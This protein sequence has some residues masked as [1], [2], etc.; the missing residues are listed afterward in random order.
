MAFNPEMEYVAL[1]CAG[2]TYILAEALLASVVAACDL[3]SAIAPGEPT[4]QADVLVRFAGSRLEGATFQHPFLDRSILGVT[5]P[6]VT[7]EQG[8]GGGPH[9]AGSRCR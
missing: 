7:A 3:K 9:F 6:Y 5:A 2:G 1:A 4:S 8:T